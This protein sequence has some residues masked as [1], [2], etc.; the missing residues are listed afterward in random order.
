MAIFISNALYIQNYVYPYVPIPYIVRNKQ[1]IGWTS[2]YPV[3]QVSSADTAA[4][5]SAASVWSADTYTRWKSLPAG[6]AATER[7]LRFNIPAGSAPVDYIGIA[8][9]NF[10]DIGAAYQL[11]SSVDNV[12]WEPVHDARTPADNKAIIEFF[13]AVSVPQYELRITIPTG[14]SGASIAHIKL[15]GIT[16]LQRPSWQGVVPAGMDKRV[17]KIG[18]KSY[19]GQHL[20]S[21]LVSRGSSF[22]I[23][24]KN[25]TVDFVRSKNLQDFFKHAR[26]LIKLSAGPTETFFYAWRPDDHPDEVQYCGATMKFD[27]P[28][29]T[30]GTTSG[31]LMQWSM[32]GDAFE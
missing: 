25:N 31:G 1:L 17:E 28:S 18:S 20:G 10:S 23:E 11:F 4:G 32:S 16:Q 2:Y 19:S 29:N 15:G 7:V 9:H 14:Q 5:Y 13:D 24:Q 21:V 6:G 27:P 8:G 22:S 3:N 26:D 12:N 30:T